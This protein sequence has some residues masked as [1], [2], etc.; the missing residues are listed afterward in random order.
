M[1]ERRCFLI[2][3]QR[4]FAWV[5]E[6]VCDGVDACLVLCVSTPWRVHPSFGVSRHNGIIHFLIKDSPHKPHSLIVQVDRP[7]LPSTVGLVLSREPRAWQP[8]AAVTP[9]A[10]SLAFSSKRCLSVHEL[11]KH[12]RERNNMAVRE[13]SSGV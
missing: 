1:P 3:S 6:R 13:S 12:L 10:A 4:A 5:H 9:H 2:S 11:G 7:A 8:P